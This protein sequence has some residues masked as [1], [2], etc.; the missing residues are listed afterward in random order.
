MAGTAGRPDAA[1]RPGTAGRPDAV[2]RPDAA[3]TFAGSVGLWI[4]AYPRRWRVVRGDELAGL[5][6]DLA[7]PGARGVDAR[8]ALDL[9]R[10]G[11]ATRWRGR[12]PLHVWLLYRM[13][14][15]RIPRGYRGWAQDDIRGVAFPVRRALGYVWWWFGWMLTQAEWGTTLVQLGVGYLVFAG[16]AWPDYFRH[17]HLL[18]HVAPQPGEPLV[19]GTLITVPGPRRRLAAR[20]SLRLFAA[21]CAVVA[22]AGA[23]TTL[24]A[25]LG[26]WTR[27]IAEN[28]TGLETG[29]GPITDRTPAVVVLLASVVVGLWAARAVRGR[30]RRRLTA[31][32]DQPYRAMSTR[33]RPSG[34]GGLVVLVGGLLAVMVAEV[35][36]DLP[37][38]FAPVLAGTAL[39]LLPGT[40][41]AIALVGPAT[42]PGASGSPDPAALTGA[43][44]WHMAAEDRAPFEDAPL[45]VLHPLDATVDLGAVMPP[46]R[47]GD[48][49]FALG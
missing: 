18:K 43:D 13:F 2:G 26:L 35:T 28:P 24:I 1:G 36:G 7:A 21:T 22:V 34:I 42:A 32:V 44:V 45:P 9:V 12:P 46:R 41:V 19:E 23:V 30:L 37:L 14:D 33:P 16:V 6:A 17:Q 38:I 3:E 10:G 49:P 20:V 48:P 31:P 27:R 15:R 4:R 29:A 40:L 5:L 39:F 25:P 47:L 8:T 11:L